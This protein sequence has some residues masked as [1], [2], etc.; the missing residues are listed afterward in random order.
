MPSYNINKEEKKFTNYSS[1]EYSYSLKLSQK[2]EKQEIKLFIIWIFI[3]AHLS[4]IIILSGSLEQLWRF[5]CET[6]YDT[7]IKNHDHH[8][9]LFILGWC[10]VVLSLHYNS[11]FCPC[12]SGFYSLLVNSFDICDVKFITTYNHEGG[13]RFVRQSML[14]MPYWI[15]EQ[16]SG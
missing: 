4:C 8:T 14:Y 11:C 7:L 2:R 3:F 1:Y 6:F 12:L 15:F 16:L 5:C 10:F 13:L 9:L